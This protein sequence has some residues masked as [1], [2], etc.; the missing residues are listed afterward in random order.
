VLAAGHDAQ[1]RVLEP[2]RH[3]V[4]TALRGRKHKSLA[5]RDQK[6]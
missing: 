4:H 5:P 2:R 1:H 6:L 3:Y